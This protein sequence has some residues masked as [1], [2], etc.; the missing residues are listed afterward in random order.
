MSA[1]PAGPPTY[2]WSGFDFYSNLPEQDFY[3]F[4][5]TGYAGDLLKSLNRNWPQLFQEYHVL[6]YFKL[7]HD[8]SEWVIATSTKPLILVVAA[9]EHPALP[10][11]VVSKAAVVFKQ[12]VSPNESA[13]YSNLHRIPVGPSSVFPNVPVLPFAGRTHSVFFAGNLHRGRRQLYA[14][15]TRKHWMPFAILHRIRALLGTNFSHLFPRSAISFSAQFHAGF[16]PQKYAECLAQSRIVLC[17]YGVNEAETMRHFEAIKQGCIVVTD[18]M[19]DTFYFKG[20]PFITIKNWRGLRET[21]ANLLSDEAAMSRYHTDT[22]TWW[23][24]QCSVEAVG[25][26]MHRIIQAAR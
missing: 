18:E 23:D 15:L 7:V 9:H 6:L 25:R 11:D 4:R 10:A 22:L 26:R 12:Y 8:T 14:E 5:E 24:S 19:P 16:T 3:A 1:D 21:L 13:R 20:A 2:K 17:P